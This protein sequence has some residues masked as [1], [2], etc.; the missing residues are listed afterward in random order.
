MHS[1]PPYR[2]WLRGAADIGR[3]MRG[4]GAD[5]RGSRLVPVRGQRRRRRL[6]Q[7][8]PDPAGGHRPFSIQLVEAAG[9]RITRLTH[10]LEPGSSRSSGC[11]SRLP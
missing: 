3:W 1:M 5:C 10:F 4:P 7:Y 11:P 2:I 9:G 8:R 6:A